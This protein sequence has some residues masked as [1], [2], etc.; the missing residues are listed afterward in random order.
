V[1][2]LQVLQDAEYI[3]ARPHLIGQL[4]LTIVVFRAVRSGPDISPGDFFLFGDPR[5]ELKGEEFEAR[6]GLQGRMGELFGQ[7]T[8]EA[9]R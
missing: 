6:A 2:A 4:C 9:L 7:A 5:P 3:L 8:L 1:S